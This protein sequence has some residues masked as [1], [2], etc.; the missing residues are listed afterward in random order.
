[1]RQEGQKVRKDAKGTQRDTS[2]TQALT[3]TQHPAFQA[4]FTGTWDEFLVAGEIGVRIVTGIPNKKNS[5][6]GSE[7]CFVCFWLF[8]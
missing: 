5:K 8:V 1:V 3:W 7:L 4:I 2:R 6:D